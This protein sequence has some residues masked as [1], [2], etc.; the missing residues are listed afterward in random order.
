MN[1][2]LKLLPLAIFVALAA[3]LAKGLTLDPSKLPSPLIDKP[4]PAFTSARLPASEGQ[5]DSQSMD[6][7]VWVLNVW[8]S[9]CGP[10]VEEHPQLKSLVAQR[11]VP[12]IGLNYKD[13]P[14]DAMAW[15]ARL[16]DPFSHLL[17]DEAGEVGL[18]WGV[19]GVPETFVIDRNGKVR[20]KHVGP[21]S[22]E[23]LESKL[24]PII[25]QLEQEPA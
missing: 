8:A 20:F 4:A 5:F 10:C 6:G 13:A 18:D 25:D 2:A 11:S 24:L 3:F 1:L 15:L 22:Q 23:D 16:G 12:L 19:Y 9:W 7:Q 17:G 21:L 14:D